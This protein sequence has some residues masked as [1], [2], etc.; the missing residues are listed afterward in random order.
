MTTYKGMNPPC[1]G[2]DLVQFTEARTNIG[3]QGFVTLLCIKRRLRMGRWV[4]SRRLISDAQ[5]A[6][7]L[8]ILGFIAAGALIVFRAYTVSR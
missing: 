3:P 7:L 4:Q 2:A 8:L 5:V 6:I 1:L